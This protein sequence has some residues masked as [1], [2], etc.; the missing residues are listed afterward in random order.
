M[1][2]TLQLDR[3]ECIQIVAITHYNIIFTDNDENLLQSVQPATQ[4]AVLTCQ[5]LS[6]WETE[7][8]QHNFS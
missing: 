8:Q 5:E 1:Q 6:L 2:K 7:L 3:T 4:L